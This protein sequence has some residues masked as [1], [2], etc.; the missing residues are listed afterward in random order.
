MDARPE[1]FPEGRSSKVEAEQGLRHWIARAMIEWAKPRMAS[2][3]LHP[4][5]VR[6]RVE[7]HEDAAGRARPDLVADNPTSLSNNGSQ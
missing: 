6:Q 1:S 2:R 7:A 5:S 4:V 3:W